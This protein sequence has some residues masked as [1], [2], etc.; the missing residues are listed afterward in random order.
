MSVLVDE[1]GPGGFIAHSF[2]GDDWR[3]CRTFIRARLG[4]A[5]E[6][7]R[8]QEPAAR[9]Q[10]RQRDRM[11]DAESLERA[12]F[13]WSLR[14]PI[15]G[16]PV[17]MYLRA[18]RAYRGP[19]PCTIGYLPPR[20]GHGPAMIAAFALAIEIEPGILELRPSEV[21]AVHITKLAADGAS[22]LKTPDS[23]VIVGRGAAG[24][25]IAISAPNDLLGL[26]ICEGVEDTLSV[27]ESTGLG[28]WAAGSAQRMPALS[29]A[30]P[31][32]IDQVTVVGHD[33][34]GRKSA[35]ELVERL[36]ARGLFAVLKILR[37][38]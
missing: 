12:R 5:Y 18:A 29:G 34:A 3:T 38:T 4:L 2:A 21:R 7:R 35:A 31:S 36:R 22:R 37:A 9:S 30:V 6:T 16:T 26:A 19:I 13:L 28:A 8:R 1:R 24:V 23:K 15:D 33:D 20:H 17:E 10:P 25:P 14:Q 32:F 27:F 11:T